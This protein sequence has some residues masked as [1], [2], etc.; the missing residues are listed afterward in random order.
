VDSKISMS[1]S[2]TADVALSGGSLNRS[3]VY[4]RG[5]CHLDRPPPYSSISAR[6]SAKAGLVAGHLDGSG[7][8]THTIIS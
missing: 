8:N 6:R 2:V 3:R 1:I 7:Y 5:I 4:R